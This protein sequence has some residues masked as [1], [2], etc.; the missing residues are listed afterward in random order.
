MTSAKIILDS[1]SPNGVRLT[2][3]EVTCHRWVLA[4]LNT[5]R[6]FSRNSRSSRAVPVS[7]TLEEVKNN[8]AMPIEWGI[9]GPGMSANGEIDVISKRLAES[10]WLKQR[11]HAVATVEKLQDMHLHKQVANRLLEP[12]M[13]HTVIITSTEWQNFFN[14]RCSPDAQPEIRVAAELMKDAWIFSHVQHVDYGEWH[15][16]YLKYDDLEQ[17]LM[18]DV[19]NRK[20]VSAARCAR[21]SYLTH[22][23]IRDMVKDLDLY[24]KLVSADPPHYSPLEHVATPVKPVKWYTPWRKEPLGNFDGWAQLRHLS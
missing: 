10:L 3:M 18:A 4:E 7:R 22:D 15:T 11:D 13:W 6:A 17:S 23:G 21:V 5:H 16:P 19:E 1:I 24:D 14:Q 9:A 2:S 8:P 20:K 12:F